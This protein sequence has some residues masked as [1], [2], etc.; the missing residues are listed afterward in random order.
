[1]TT[2]ILKKMCPKCGKVMTSLYKKQLEQNYAM[3]VMNCKT[4]K[5]EVQTNE[6]DNASN[7]SER[8]I[9]ER[10]RDHSFYAID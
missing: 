5:K 7:K 8:S 4:E 10:K 1:M 9:E 2:E 3:H 6:N